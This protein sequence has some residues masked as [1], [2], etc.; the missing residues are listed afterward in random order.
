M[1]SKIGG[2]RYSIKT[3]YIG[4]NSSY[5]IRSEPRSTDFVIATLNTINKD[6]NAMARRTPIPAFRTAT[7][8][9]AHRNATI[10]ILWTKDSAL[11][12]ADIIKA[13]M[14]TARR[15]A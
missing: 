9:G 6:E 11:I 7:T 13:P 8:T 12:V 10:S 1:A 4:E 2:N 15:A 3:T 14:I 5:S